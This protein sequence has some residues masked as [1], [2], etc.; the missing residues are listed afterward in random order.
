[1]NWSRW[2]GTWDPST[3]CPP[4][5]CLETPPAPTELLH[6][7]P[8]HPRH[9]PS[10]PTPPGL[11]HRV[12]AGLPR[13]E[14][15]LPRHVNQSHGDSLKV[16]RIE[17]T[18]QEGPW[19][20]SLSSLLSKC[21][22]LL[23]RKPEHL[24]PMQFAR[25]PLVPIPPLP[26]MF[27]FPQPAINPSPS[28]T[29]T[30]FPRLTPFHPLTWTG[31]PHHMRTFSVPTPLLRLHTTGS[32]KFVPHERTPTNLPE[33]TPTIH[34]GTTPRHRLRKMPLW[35]LLPLKQH[36]SQNWLYQYLT[37]FSGWNLV[38]LIKVF[39]LKS[40]KLK[41]KLLLLQLFIIPFYIVSELELLVF[42]YYL[43]LYIIIHSTI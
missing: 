32:Q 11:R 10:A 20:K 40:T 18:Q 42:P 23:A 6:P 9:D 2:S 15:S 4:R 35:R 17:K 41:R 3:S 28:L 38:Y 19:V 37:V 12:T 7:E 36:A 13:H 31:T 8:Q 33:R 22:F 34:L 29:M 21:I 14:T 1:M 24:D 43:L 26:K 30:L 16:P 5:R 25:T 39:P 27:P